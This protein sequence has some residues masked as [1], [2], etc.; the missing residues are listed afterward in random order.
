V[1]NAVPAARSW[2]AALERITPLA[3]TFTLNVFVAEKP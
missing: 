3:R 1:L 2:E